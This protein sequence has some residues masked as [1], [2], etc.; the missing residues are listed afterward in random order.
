M[1]GKYELIQSI[2]ISSKMDEES[3][4]RNLNFLIQ[5][6]CKNGDVEIVISDF[7]ASMMETAEKCMLNALI[8]YYAILSEKIGYNLSIK[9]NRK[10]PEKFLNRLGFFLTEQE[11][12]W[13]EGYVVGT[14]YTFIFK[15]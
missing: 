15:K 7:E 11:E 3:I 6:N 5:R 10:I 13:N 4:M 8:E 14:L 2:N 12:I 9:M 1:A